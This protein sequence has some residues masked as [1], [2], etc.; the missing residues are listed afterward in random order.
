MANEA[1]PTFFFGELASLPVSIASIAASDSPNRALRLG[2]FVGL[3][4][5]PSFGKF[6]GKSANG[7]TP[8]LAN[9]S[10]S[11]LHSTPNS[12]PNSAVN[13]SAFPCE[14]ELRMTSAT[15]ASNVSNDGVRVLPKVSTNDGVTGCEPVLVPGISGLVPLI[16]ARFRVLCFGRGL[17]FAETKPRSE[18][19][20]PLLGEETLLGGEV[21][22]EVEK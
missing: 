2:S 17:G 12:L 10:A 3:P 15:P 6:L 5:W 22:G 14:N 1:S 8:A 7:A 21:E 4:A 20:L 19:L 9:S 11:A 13:L 18:I 16:L